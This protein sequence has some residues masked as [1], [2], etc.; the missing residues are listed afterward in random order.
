MRKDLN[1]RKIGL[2]FLF[3]VRL[4]FYFLSEEDED[5]SYLFQCKVKFSNQ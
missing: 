1:Y 3:A 4:L 2:T 5:N